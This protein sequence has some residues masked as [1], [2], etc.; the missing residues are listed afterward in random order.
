MEMLVRCKKVGV[1]TMLPAF[2]L[3]CP[4]GLG[5]LVRTKTKSLLHRQTR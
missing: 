3:V 1:P 2:L 4:E 5:Y